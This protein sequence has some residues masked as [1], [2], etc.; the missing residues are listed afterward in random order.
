MKWTHNWRRLWQVT[1]PRPRRMV[2]PL[3][4]KQ[5]ERSEVEIFDEP[6]TAQRNLLVDDNQS[7]RD[8][9]GAVLKHSGFEVVTAA[10]VNDALR[11][12]SSETF[13]V[14]LSDLHMPHA[15]DGLTVV[16]AMRNSNPKA[17][18]FIFSGY[19]EMN[20]AAAAILL[21]ADEILVKPMEV[22]RLVKTI[23]D[24]LKQGAGP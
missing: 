22:K 10:N 2:S 19:P 13:D 5:V 20:E 15:G 1:S 12:I 11:L 17:I 4:H 18:T 3:T 14:L 7:I 16:S 9:L 21:Q 6:T 24:R 23:K 8:S